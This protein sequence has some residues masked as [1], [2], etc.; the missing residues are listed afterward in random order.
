[1]ASQL[2]DKKNGVSLQQWQEMV[3]ELLP[4]KEK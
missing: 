4:D 2:H 1:M 3:A